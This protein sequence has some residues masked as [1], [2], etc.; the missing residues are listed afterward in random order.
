M[1]KIQKRLRQQ[2]KSKLLKTRRLKI[3]L[4]NHNLT[5]KMKSSE[6]SKL[7]YPSKKL[8]ILRE[9][10]T[11]MMLLTLLMQLQEEPLDKKKKENL[12]H[13]LTLLRRK[14]N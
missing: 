4:P 3:N 12:M 10:R 8:R 9:Q 6:R 13:Q 11:V 5:K 7:N 2:S 1:L 14:E